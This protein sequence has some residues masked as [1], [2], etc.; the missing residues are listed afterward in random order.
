MENN[1]TITQNLAEFIYGTYYRWSFTGRLHQ[2]P[3]TIAQYYN[4]IKNAFLRYKKVRSRISW[5]CDTISYGKEHFPPQLPE[6]Q[7]GNGRSGHHGRHGG[8]FR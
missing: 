5:S 1:T 8:C 3:E 4:D 2:A 6:G 7:R